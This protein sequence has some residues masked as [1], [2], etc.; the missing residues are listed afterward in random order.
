MRTTLACGL[1]VACLAACGGKDNKNKDAN[2]NGEGQPPDAPDFLKCAAPVNG[3]TVSMRKL[4]MQL[5][6]DIGVLVTSPPNDLRLFVVDRS[7]QI[8]IVENEQ[9]TGTFID[10]QDDNGGPVLASTSTGELGLLGLAFHPNYAQNRTFFVFYT[11]SQSGD[12]TNPFRDVVAR[13][14]ASATDPNK[15]DPTCTE[16]LVIPDF[17]ANHNGGMIEF[18]KDGYLYISTGDGGKADDPNKNGQALTDNPGTNT[19]ALLAKILRID[20][21]NKAGGKEYGIPSDNPFAAGGGAPEIFAIGL[22]NAWR[23]SFDRANG[24]VWIGDVGQ[25]AIEEL[26]YVKAGQ[27]KGKNFGWSTCEGS[28]NFN[29]TCPTG[30]ASFF[31]PQ[32]ERTHAGDAWKSITGGQVY[33]G[34]CYPDI[35][36]SY[37]YTDFDKGGLSK[38]TVRGDGTLDI[39]DLPGTFPGELTSIHEVAT[40]EIYATDLRGNVF[41]LEAGP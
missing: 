13:C 40:G 23:W 9:I 22:R 32:D 29:G 33:R 6:T 41:H 2:G 35:V 39:Q 36:G 38:A 37:F 20:V 31:F 27:L 7:G 12:G 14:T 3:T 16:I 4:P 25:G 17:A 19:V 26:D 21:D 5:P 8:V 34:T 24:D 30:N 18:G 1:V 15:A 11:R 28:L 10:L